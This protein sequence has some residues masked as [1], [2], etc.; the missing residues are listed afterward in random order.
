VIKW[1]QGS[2]GDVSEGMRDG[3]LL[4]V[5]V[6]LAPE[7]VALTLTAL[8][9]VPLVFGAWRMSRAQGAAR[10]DAAFTTLREFLMYIAVLQAVTVTG[11]L[12]A[13]R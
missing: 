13:Q 11:L 12:Q 4:G 5:F 10:T 3:L 1:G 9:A 6:A 8:A 2:A 7:I